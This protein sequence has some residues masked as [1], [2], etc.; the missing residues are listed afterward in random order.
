M[1]IEQTSRTVNEVINN[2]L[3][4]FGDESGVQLTEADVINSINKA[5]RE[6]INQNR[7]INQVLAVLDITAEKDTYE[8]VN[9]IP[10]IMHI[11]SIMMGNKF[12]PGMKFEDAQTSI[13]EQDDTSGN[14]QF[15][16]IFAGVLNLW[17]SPVD[18]VEAG[19]KIYYNKVP[20]FIR[21]SGELLGVPDTYFNAVIDYCLKDAYEL[22]E[23]PQMAGT[24]M[25]D[26][27]RTIATTANDTSHQL[28]SYPTI[29][30]VD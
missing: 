11:H 23:N 13:M 12:L 9:E 4:I 15:W 18:D 6:L 8:L 30:E 21:E 24:K 5:Q 22:D 7:E 3:R 10:D 25:E 17:P 14:P 20:P 29:R 1:A 28:R 2:V 26:F 16:Y 27:G 19:L